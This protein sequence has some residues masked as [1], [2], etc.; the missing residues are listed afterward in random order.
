MIDAYFSAIAGL[1][2]FLNLNALLAVGAKTLP[3]AGI[4][5]PVSG[6]STVQLSCTTQ[7]LLIISTNYRITMSE[8]VEN[9]LCRF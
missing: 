6:I 2:K 7:A 1:G 8:L 4:E 3:S 9:S 5:Q